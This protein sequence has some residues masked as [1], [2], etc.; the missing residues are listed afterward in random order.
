VNPGDSNLRAAR[1]LYRGLS[2]LTAIVLS[3]AGSVAAGEESNSS[4]DSDVVLKAMS[5]ELAREKAQ[6]KLPG[7]PQPYFIRYEVVEA[8]NHS[9]TY[10]LGTKCADSENNGRTATIDLRVGNYDFD[11]AIRLDTDRIR[12]STRA[13]PIDND[14]ATRMRQSN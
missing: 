6:L 8:R 12:P 1:C 5:D 9:V 11:N 13:L 3:G 2:L 7:K 14:Y 4:A 10:E